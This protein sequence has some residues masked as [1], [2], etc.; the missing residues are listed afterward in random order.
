MNSFT[1][2][3]TSY[4][5]L[6]QYE[7]MCPKFRDFYDFFTETFI[8]G[9]YFFVAGNND[10]KI[11]DCGGDFGMSAIYFK[12]LYPEATLL[13]FEPSSSRY[14]CLKRNIKENDI[15]HTKALNCALSSKN[16]YIYF[17]IM[18]SRVRGQNRMRTERVRC[19]RL[20]DYINDVIDLLKVD[21]EGS[22]YDVMK[23]VHASGKLTNVKKMFLEYH[24]YTEADVSRMREIT[25]LI[26]NNGFRIYARRKKYHY[27]IYA[28]N[29]LFS[30][31]LNKEH[32]LTC[33]ANIVEDNRLFSEA[34]S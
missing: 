5:R 7:I 32:M 8:E 18:K 14:S 2:Q 28:V 13:I 3:R 20:S 34:N 1:R 29:Q 24:I 4:I 6:F 25:E 27:V 17:D 9:E 19:C 31:K 15:A 22:E 12:C 26:K 16:G 10:P 21:I 33:S 23:E 30:N 11:I